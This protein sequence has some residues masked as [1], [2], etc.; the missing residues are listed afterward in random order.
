[1]AGAELRAI[2]LPARLDAIRPRFG[3]AWLLL[4]E[5]LKNQQIREEYPNACTAASN[6]A[7]MLKALKEPTSNPSDDAWS[8][9]KDFLDLLL[10]KGLLGK[11]DSAL[12]IDIS[13]LP[14]YLLEEKRGYS[15][16]T[17][18]RNIHNVLPTLDHDMLSD[19]VYE[20]M[21]EAGA[22]LAFER[23]TGCGYHMAR[24]VED[25]ARHYYSLITARSAEYIDN[26]DVLRYRMLG[27]ITEELKDILDKR[28]KGTEP[29]LLSLVVPILR[30]FCRIYRT[31][32]AHA[33]PEL[34]KLEPN[35]AEIAFAHAITAISTMF[36]DV[37]QGGPH[38]TLSFK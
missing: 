20:N 38:F 31:R 4:E 34:E 12:D 14:I 3:S 35:D 13:A 29:E 30:Q 32:L 36:E 7:G 23:Y 8:I 5:I 28:K 6:L 11:M 22:C 24:A 16:S 21:Q 37:R 1:L 26:N 15:I 25:V 2:R 17:L 19:F 27:Q 10:D 18:L 33:D 9:D